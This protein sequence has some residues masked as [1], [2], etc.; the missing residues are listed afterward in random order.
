MMRTWSPSEVGFE[1][2]L[3]LLI[4]GLGE[5]RDTG[6]GTGAILRSGMRCLKMFNDG[7]TG[8]GSAAHNLLI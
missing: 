2:E 6:I 1:T 8:C 3:P 5:N 4:V 7:W